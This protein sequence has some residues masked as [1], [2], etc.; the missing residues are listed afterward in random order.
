M[1]TQDGSLNTKLDFGSGA[2]VLQDQHTL[3]ATID[4]VKALGTSVFGPVCGLCRRGWD[5]GDG[6]PLAT[7]V[8][9]PTV[10]ISLTCPSD[11]ARPAR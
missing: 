5:P 6:V 1:A 9:L 11:P 3:R 7:L 8:R 10:E 2:L 4:P